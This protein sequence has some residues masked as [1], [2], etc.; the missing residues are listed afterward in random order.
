M[1]PF[2][3]QRVPCAPTRANRPRQQS[4]QCLCRGTPRAAGGTHGPAGV[5]LPVRGPGAVAGHAVPG[6]TQQRQDEQRPGRP[7]FGPDMA[8][9]WRAPSDNVLMVKV[10]YWLSR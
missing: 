9:L 4:V 7:E 6:W 5:C 2:R 3:R 8:A 10:S 1:L